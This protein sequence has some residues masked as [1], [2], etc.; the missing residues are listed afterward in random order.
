MSDPEFINKSGTNSTRLRDLKP[1]STDLPLVVDISETAL[2]SLSCNSEIGARIQALN[3]RSCRLN[4]LIGLSYLTRLEELDI[5][6][7][8]LKVIFW[9]NHGL[10]FLN[11]RLFHRI[12]MIA[13]LRHWQD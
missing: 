9:V 8:Q 12:E 2:T 3:V 5:G 11:F 13:K 6:F 7:N 10:I 4:S 1:T